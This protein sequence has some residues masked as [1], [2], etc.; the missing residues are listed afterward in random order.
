VNMKQRNLVFLF[1][2]LS[3]YEFSYVY[4]AVFQL[5]MLHVTIRLLTVHIPLLTCKISVCF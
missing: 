4:Q 1:V 5:N 3:G 2:Y